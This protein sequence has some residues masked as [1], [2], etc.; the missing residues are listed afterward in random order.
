[1]KLELNG[2]V[3]DFPGLTPEMYKKGQME[4]YRLALEAGDVALAS[5]IDRN[6]MRLRFNRIQE[7]K[8]P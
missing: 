2:V 3:E 8:T 5:R 7:A 4:M 6:L 1:M